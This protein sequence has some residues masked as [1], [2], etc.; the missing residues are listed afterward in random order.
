MRKRLLG[1]LACVASLT[2]G[3][4][5]AQE[6]V[7]VGVL[8]DTSSI[9]A[10]ISGIGSV[11]AVKLA[12]E[13]AGGSVLGKPIEVISADHQNKAD[14]GTNI[15]RQWFD[16]EN[17]D[18]ILDVNNSAVAFGVTQLAKAKNKIVLLVGAASTELTASY[19]TPVSAQWLYDTY[20]VVRGTVDAA[21]A[22]GPKTWYFITADYAFGHSLESEASA[23]IEKGGG[24]VL[25]KVRVPMGTADYASF[26]L[27]A[28]SSKADVIGLALSGG[29]LVNVVKQGAEFG[30]TQGGQKF[31]AMLAT[32]ADIK[33]IGP[34]AAGGMQFSSPFYWD[35]DD[36]TRAFAV[37]FEKRMK[38]PPTMMQ[39]GVYS[40]ANHYFKAIKAAG[41]KDSTA[42]MSK[43][44]ELPI[45]DF[46]TKN[47][48]LRLDGRVVRDVHLFEA[49][50]PK[51]SKSSWDIYKLIS[52]TP[53]NV[54][55][56]PLNPACPLVK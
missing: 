15:A 2:P 28:Q 26:L 22:K 29:D 40:A 7:K 30:I 56:K 34:A 1:V 10:D 5:F 54:V 3:I 4:L 18:A 27:Q 39:A 21:Q 31:A 37:R 19:C 16:R 38:R 47:G 43:M 53:G 32:E 13:D 51:E 12:I 44:H 45:D 48:V 8:T 46:M 11:E 25:G 23:L 24:K 41:T 49:K 42:V 50:S 9:Y 35:L 36:A 14:V 6:G 52:T 33:T 55:T 20:S 17:V